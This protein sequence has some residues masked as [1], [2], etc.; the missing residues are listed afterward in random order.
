M[1]LARRQWRESLGESDQFWIMKSHQMGIAVG[2]EWRLRKATEAR[3][4]AKYQSELAAAS[5]RQEK[6]AIERKMQ[7][8]IREEMKRIASPYSLWGSR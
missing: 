2:G 7:Q 4:R 5:D 6:A 1:S 3:I 8:E